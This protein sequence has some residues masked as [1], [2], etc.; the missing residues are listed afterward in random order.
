M[1]ARWV[2]AWLGLL[3]GSQFSA[4]APAVRDLG[5]GLSYVRIRE[6]PGDL[7]APPAGGPAAWV[8]DVRYVAAGREAAVAFAAWLKFRATPRSPVFVLANRDTS[9]ELRVAL[10]GPHR[11]TG[12][13]VIGIPGPDFVPDVPVRS[14]P[15]TEKR[16]FAALEEGTPLSVLLKD[17]PE[18]A[19]NDEARLVRSATAPAV[20]EEA[21]EEK[22][23]V[24]IPVDAALQRA[25]HLQ[26]SL[27]AMRRE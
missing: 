24:A 4:A 5:H 1:T 3:V 18:K 7:P 20:G 12:I 14:N 10:Q 15:E 17:H 25:L 27:G 21:T 2:V 22:A 26:Q 8:I 6:L 9:A 16:A 19:R 23:A 11:G 13:A